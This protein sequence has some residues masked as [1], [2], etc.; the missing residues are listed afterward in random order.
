MRWAR[1]AKLAGAHGDL[2]TVAVATGLR[3][4]EIT[5]LWAG[6]IDVAKGSVQVSKTW[7]RTTQGRGARSEIPGWLARQVQAKHTMRGHH[8][9]APVTPRARRTVTVAPTVAELLVKRTRGKAS[10]DFVF[11]TRRGLPW[12][13][14]DF[15]NHVWTKLMTK[16]EAD[17][18]ARFVFD[19]LRHTHAAWLL[20][21]GVQLHDLQARLGHESITTTIETYGHLLPTADDLVSEIIG[22]ALVEPK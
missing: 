10:D 18:T 5:A 8:L 1:A 21:G 12:H 2:L 22:T 13:P 7:K 3:F 16:L 9:A 11:N 14:D 17:G 4:G 15:S 19:D 20:E 6:D